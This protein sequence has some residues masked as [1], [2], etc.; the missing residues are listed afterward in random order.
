[1]FKYNLLMCLNFVCNFSKRR[2]D[3]TDADA[4][5]RHPG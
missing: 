4:S 5:S 3:W 2:R 1:M